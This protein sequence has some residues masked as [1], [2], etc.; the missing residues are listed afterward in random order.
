MPR[1]GRH[2]TCAM[3][4]TA[5]AG[6]ARTNAL[7]TH[8]WE[9]GSPRS[10]PFNPLIAAPRADRAPTRATEPASNPRLRHPSTS[11]GVAATAKKRAGT[12]AGSIM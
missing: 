12:M 4:T 6:M 7:I 11:A 2:R 5:T 10:L 8:Q 9:C 1:S 3:M